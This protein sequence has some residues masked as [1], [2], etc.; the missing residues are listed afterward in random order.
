M[1]SHRKDNLVQRQ[2]RLFV[3]QTEQNVRVL[4]QWRDT[5]AP[6]LGR[7]A[8]GLPKALTQMIAVLALTANSSAAAR[9]EAPPSTSAITR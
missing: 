3:N 2:V 6:R 1:L 7:A 5:S 4:F 8:A 9:R